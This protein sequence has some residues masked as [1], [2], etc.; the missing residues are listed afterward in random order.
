MIQIKKLNKNY[1]Q[2]S[3]ESLDVLIDLDFVVK[4][5]QFVSIIGH[6]GSGKSTLLHILGLLDTPSKVKEL[7][8][9]GEEITKLSLPQRTRFRGKN[10]G[11]I[12]QFHQLLPEFIA[13]DNV[14]LPMRIHGETKS[15][16]KQRAMDLLARV[17]SEEEMNTKAHLRREC[18][19]SGGQCQRVAIAR[20]LANNP[21]VI[22]ADEP[23]GS[24]DPASAE[25]VMS[26][27][28]SLPKEGK[29]VVMIT[30]QQELAN[31]AD[32]VYN[33]HRGRLQLGV[34]V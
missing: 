27:L 14:M 22:L 8:L 18:Q 29:T 15:R 10:L 7:K 4:K 17:L 31:K 20:A 13:L 5:G 28:M 3:G 2:P 34:G 32:S 21:P 19:L 11:F 6:S 26:I 23:T 9:C 16:A 1:K 12:F 30:H 25:K 24:L 33:L